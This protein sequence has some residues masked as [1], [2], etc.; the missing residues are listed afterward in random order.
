MFLLPTEA[1]A[2][3]ANDPFLVLRALSASGRL[4]VLDRILQ[5]LSNV[6]LVGRSTRVTAVEHGLI[7]EVEENV[8]Q[9]LVAAAH[10]K[11]RVA[12]VT[13]GDVERLFQAVLNALPAEQRLCVSFTTGLKDSAR[14][15][16]QMFVVPTDP[17]M[18]RQT[19]RTSA[20]RIVD[21]AG[22]QRQLPVLGCQ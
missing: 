22:N 17:A 14:R 20:A 16:F 8:F 1:L 12:I 4:A 19:Q 11:E 7:E 13:N 18:V 9:S 6:P 2:A 10:H 3:F 21:L 5:T 15:P